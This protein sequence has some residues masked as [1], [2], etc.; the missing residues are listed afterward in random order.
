MHMLEPTQ[1]HGSDRPGRRT[2]HHP[3]RDPACSHKPKGSARTPDPTNS[4]RIHV[5]APEFRDEG[6]PT[7][8][9]VLVHPR[10]QSTTR[11]QATLP[12]HPSTDEIRPGHSRLQRNRHSPFC[13]KPAGSDNLHLRSECSRLLSSPLTPPPRN[14]DCLPRSAKA[15]QT[16]RTNSRDHED[17]IP[18][19]KGPSPSPPTRSEGG[20]CI[21]DGPSGSYKLQQHRPRVRQPRLLVP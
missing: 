15:P 16:R 19:G 14:S 17:T 18:P 1:P 10:P 21:A 12:W 6:G 13:L 8:S 7:E 2:P 4:S 9:P 3:S 5:L 20:K 11:R